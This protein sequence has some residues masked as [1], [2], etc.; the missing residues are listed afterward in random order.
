MAL[1][2]ATILDPS[3]KMDFLDLF[4][5]KTCQ[6]FIDI[7]KNM[8][9]AKQWFTKFFGEYAKKMFKK[10]LQSHLLLLQILVL[11]AHRF[12]EKKVG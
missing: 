11:W 9:L 6:Q 2:I 3:K 10:I 12:L 1:I 7:Q 4:Y 8:S 5:E